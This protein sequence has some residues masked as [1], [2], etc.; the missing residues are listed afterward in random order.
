MLA[1]LDTIRDWIGGLTGIR[2]IRYALDKPR[3]SLPYLMAHLT[4]TLPL[5]QHPARI[6]ATGTDTDPTD[7]IV[8]DMELRVSLSAYGDAAMDR[9]KVFAGVKFLPGVCAPLGAVRLHEVGRIQ[10]VPE[11]VGTA[12]EDRAV[13]RLIFHAPTVGVHPGSALE[14]A[15]FTVIEEAPQ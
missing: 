13:L 7:T 4:D 15:P 14:A 10:N 1:E 9:L 3:P 5:T 6:L 11:L 8:T 12:Y 2:P